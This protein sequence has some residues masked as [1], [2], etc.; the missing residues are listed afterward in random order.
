MKRIKK[1]PPEV[2][3]KAF[4]ENDGVE[5]WRIFYANILYTHSHMFKAVLE[6]IRDREVGEEVGAVL[7][8]CTGSL[9]T[10]N[11]ILYFSFLTTVHSLLRPRIP[12]RIFTYVRYLII[13]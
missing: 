11:C 1:G 7:F 8:H 6:M 9:Y 5:A 10:L 4:T 13:T 3:T 12:S 2:P